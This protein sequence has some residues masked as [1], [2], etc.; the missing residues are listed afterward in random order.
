[1]TI[2]NADEKAAGEVTPTAKE[3]WDSVSVDEPKEEPKQEPKQE[4]ESKE[5]PAREEKPEPT[6][7]EL[8]NQ[9]ANL[10]NR[11]RAADGRSG[12][13]QKAL[14]DKEAQ[15]TQLQAEIQAAKSAP[16]TAG[17]PTQEQIKEAA[18]SPEKWAA[19]KGEFGE[20]GD[21]VEEYVT[22]QVGQIKSEFQKE[23][24]ALRR[25]LA[26]AKAN[27]E[28]TPEFREQ[29]IKE[30]QERIERNRNEA[31]LTDAHP[32]WKDIAASDDFKEWRL[33]Q[34]PEIEQLAYSLRARDAIRMFDLYLESKKPPAIREQRQQRL[35]EAATV[36][37]LGQGGLESRGRPWEQ[38]TDLERW[39]DVRI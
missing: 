2:E 30:A 27:R 8:K 14:Q 25:E 37:N 36:G 5:E 24:E 6:V 15:L 10:T 29:L 38:L 35:R 39:N 11:V 19:L 7:E 28:V 20:W 23:A 16:K 31:D 26:E 1:M 3:V 13:L 18:K 33:R 9:V 17:G 12:G 4:Q 34:P 22:S 32:T 21:G